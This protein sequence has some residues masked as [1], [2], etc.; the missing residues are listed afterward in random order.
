MKIYAAHK[1][2][3]VM[4]PDGKLG[5]VVDTMRGWAKVDGTNTFRRFIEE[6]KLLLVSR[7]DE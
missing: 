4:L 1:G 7:W 3:R 6:N 2:D 5:W